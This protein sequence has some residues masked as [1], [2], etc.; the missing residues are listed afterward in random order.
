[1]TITEELQANFA[2]LY[3]THFRDTSFGIESI[4]A[5]DFT[6]EDREKNRQLLDTSQR[7]ILFHSCFAANAPI[8]QG[9][10]S[11]TSLSGP[12]YLLVMIQQWLVMVMNFVVM[13]LCVILTSLAVNLRSN[14][15]FTG[16]SLVSLMAFGNQLAYTVV[17][18][19]Q[20]ETSM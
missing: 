19:T 17:F 18:Y 8:S 12:A 10:P 5:F 2:F 13:A 14:S 9:S 3:S 4:R 20:L 11:L 16:A 15:G 1:M 6:E 7:K